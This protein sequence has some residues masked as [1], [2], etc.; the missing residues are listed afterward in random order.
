MIYL[1]H[2]II[3]EGSRS[4]KIPSCMSEIITRVAE[5]SQRVEDLKVPPHSLEAEQSV[6]GGLMLDNRAWDEIADIINEQDFYR[7]DHALDF[8]LDQRA[9]RKRTTLRC[10]HRV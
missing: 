9:C 6:I 7:H 10:R 8:T 1:S 3:I 5:L 2:P 4:S